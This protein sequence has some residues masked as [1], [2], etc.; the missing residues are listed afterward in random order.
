M[1]A[2]RTSANIGVREFSGQVSGTTGGGERMKNAIYEYN[3]QAS[4]YVRACGAP[5]PQRSN[6][7]GRSLR[8]AAE[9]LHCLQDRR[10]DM[11][12][13][14]SHWRHIYKQL[15]INNARRGTPSKQ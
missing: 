3:T 9:P 1:R 13:D 5:D 14:A 8:T 2:K 11:Q 7:N 4:G 6:L 10:V 15:I 12:F